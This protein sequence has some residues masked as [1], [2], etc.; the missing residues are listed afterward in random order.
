AAAT[1]A[2]SVA[3]QFAFL[4]NPA[5]GK[6]AALLTIAL[7][8]LVIVRYRAVYRTAPS[9][10]VAAVLVSAIFLAQSQVSMALTTVW[11]ASWWEY[12]A[13]MLAAFGTTIFG[14]M[15][16]YAGAGSVYGVIEGLLLRDT[17]TQV[18]RGYTEVIVALVEAVEAKDHY[19]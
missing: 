13:L 15:Q 4:G 1:G 16:E 17:F 11:H 14:L 12:H 3:S 8:A 2:G 7:L 5:I 9:P 10:L 19:T 6:I 18:Q